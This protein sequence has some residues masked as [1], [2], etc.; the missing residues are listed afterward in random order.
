MHVSSDFAG[1]YDYMFNKTIIAEQIRSEFR[2]E[3]LR[4]NVPSKWPDSVQEFNH[5]LAE[6]PITAFISEA[7]QI[8]Q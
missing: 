6:L 7:E 2:L 4:G 1:Q 8:V 5:D 3:A